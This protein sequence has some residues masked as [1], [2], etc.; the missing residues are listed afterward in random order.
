[1]VQRILLSVAVFVV[2]LVLVLSVGE[3]AVRRRERSRTTVPGSMPLLFYRHERLRDALVHN[4]NYYDWVHTDANGFRGGPV[5]VPKAPGTWRVLAVGASTTFDSQVSHDTLTWP[6]RLERELRARRPDVAVEVVNT[7]VP[8]YV[9]LDNLIRLYTEFPRL[10]PDAIVLLHGHNE[11]FGTFRDAYYPR[12]AT[13]RPGEVATRT[14]WRA[15]LE[16]RS[17]LYAKLMLRWRIREF[18]QVVRSEVLA[19]QGRGDTSRVIVDGAAKYQ[20]D[21]RGFLAVARTLGIPVFVV[22]PVHL[23]G[24]GRTDDTVTRHLETWRGTVT[25]DTPE[26]VLAAY[27]EFAHAARRA[28]ESE[29]AFFVPSGT[30]GMTGDSL[31]AGG[32]PI[33]FNIQGSA[34]F[35][36][37]L[38]AAL[39]AGGWIGARP[40]SLLAADRSPPAPRP[41]R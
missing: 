33:H 26:R 5:S 28:A 6:A 38:A 36:R 7:G 9:L 41:R 11:V 17:L 37:E 22:E 32:D 1:V 15:W 30:F 16:A 3:W 19:A 20:R 13:D 25:Y 23:S 29:D 2:C 12:P 24:A 40:E 10:Q 14:P 4:R 31:Y 8:G 39:D 21:L 34:R 27:A 18:R 35:A